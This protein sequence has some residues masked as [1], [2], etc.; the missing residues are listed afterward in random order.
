MT[1]NKGQEEAA[2]G[3]FKFL[4]E[5][6]KNELVISGSG[7][8]GKTYLMGY[9]IDNIIPRYLDTCKLLGIQPK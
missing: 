3:F 4:M 1:L 8:T 7:G 5:K 9:L 2:Q 6:D